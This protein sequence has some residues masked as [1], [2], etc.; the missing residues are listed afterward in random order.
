MPL[1]LILKTPYAIDA[2]SHACTSD[3]HF[4]KRVYQPR[5]GR[6]LPCSSTCLR[7]MIRS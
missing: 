4:F 2:M 6:S 1:Q 7:S 3:T 5:F